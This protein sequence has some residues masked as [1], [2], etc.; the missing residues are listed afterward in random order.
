MASIK[1]SHAHKL[2]ERE[3][4]AVLDALIAK[5]YDEYQ[6]TSVWHGSHIDFHRSGASGKLIMHP[7]QVDIEIKLGMMLGMFEKKIRSAIIEFCEEKL[8]Q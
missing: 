7:H 8:P 3:T 5:L 6:I 2:P 4:R 1:I